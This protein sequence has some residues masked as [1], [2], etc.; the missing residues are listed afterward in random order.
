M[1]SEKTIEEIKRLN[2][3]DLLWVLFVFLS[4]ANIF[5]DYNEKE[6]LKTNDPDF[7]T[8]ANKIFEITLVVT[9]FIYIY[10]LVR[11]YHAYQNASL[12]NKNLYLIKT[13]GSSFLIA[14]I[15]L[16][17]YFQFKQSSFVGS[18]AI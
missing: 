18:P 12:E 6:F 2:F 9:F 7:K 15:V 11:N 14:G 16:L 4:I 17:I 3:E 8:R 1:F 10:F 5:G 13:L